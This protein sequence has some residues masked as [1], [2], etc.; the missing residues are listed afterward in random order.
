MMQ[1]S[2]AHGMLARR[3]PSTA[4]SHSSTRQRLRP[5]YAAAGSGAPTTADSGAPWRTGASTQAAL[6]SAVAW[7]GHRRRPTSLRQLMRRGCAAEPQTPDTAKLQ[8]A[9]PPLQRRRGGVGGVTS[10]AGRRVACRCLLDSAAVPVAP[11]QRQF[12][13]PGKSMLDMIVCCRSFA[14]WHIAASKP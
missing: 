14:G 11:Q 8:L 2:A 12:S 1:S 10:D 3:Q 6:A 5:L 9:V 13:D 7:R 4:P